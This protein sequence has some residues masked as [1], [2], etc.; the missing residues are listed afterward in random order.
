VSA[1]LYTGC[2]ET[3][4]TNPS[5]EAV[6]QAGQRADQAT[7]QAAEAEQQVR[8]ERR[9]RD[10]DRLRGQAELVELSGQLA[11]LRGLLVACS[12]TLLALAVWLAVEIRRR[13]VLT[14]AVQALPPQE[15]G[16]PRVTSNSGTSLS[17]S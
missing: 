3:P 16:K 2:G 10:I 11:L 5:Q 12:A 4:V 6:Q 8:H 1:T 7:Q 14:F 13:R 17:S 15:G 9:L